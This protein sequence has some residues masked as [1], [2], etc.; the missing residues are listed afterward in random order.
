MCQ[1]ALQARELTCRAG[2]CLEWESCTDKQLALATLRMTRHSVFKGCPSR[3]GPSFH[4]IPLWASHHKNDIPVLEEIEL[5]KNAR[6]CWHK[7]KS[8]SES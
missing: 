1:L 3:L 6:G 5:D 8:I 4:T 2:V 7:R